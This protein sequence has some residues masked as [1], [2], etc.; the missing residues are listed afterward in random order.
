MAKDPAFLFYPKD[1]LEGTAELSPEE[2]G[3]YIDLLAHQHQKK[4]LPSDTKRLAKLCGL[5]EV[6]FL[7]IW[8]GIKGKFDRMDDRMVNRKL[9]GISTERLS[10]THTNRITGKFASLIRSSK[11]LSPEII[12]GV[13]EDFDIDNFLPFS[14]EDATERLTEWYYRTVKIRLRSIANANKDEN[15][16]Y[17]DN[18]VRGVGEGEKEKWNTKPVAADLNGLPEIKLGAAQQLI[19]STQKIMVSK[20]D[21]TRIWEVFK[22]QNVTG[23]KRYMTKND[24]YSH[25][26]NWVKTQKFNNGTANKSGIGGIKPQINN[27]APGGF[28]QPGAH[29]VDRG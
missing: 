13:K 21:L 26:I 18:E 15:E 3:V 29:R 9:E 11:D 22:I 8:E 17:R 25:F 14:T 1:W 23:E 19:F 10:K 12:A 6:E 24:V 4:T 16:D 2:K 20:E 27:V 7:L 5:G 28:G